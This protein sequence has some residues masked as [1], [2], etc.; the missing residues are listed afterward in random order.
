MT[1][2][3]NLWA[4]SSSMS[5]LRD[6]ATMYVSQLHI[7]PNVKSWGTVISHIFWGIGTIWEYL[8]RLSHLYCFLYRWGWLRK[9]KPTW[10]Q[11]NGYLNI[12]TRHKRPLLVSPKMIHP[13]NGLN[14]GWWNLKIIKPD[15]GKVR[16]AIS[17]SWIQF[18]KSDCPYLTSVF[19]WQNAQ[20]GKWFTRRKCNYEHFSLW[21][22]KELHPPNYLHLIF[23][24]L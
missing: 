21:K 16:N 9:L 2:A 1:D 24:I 22:H 14:T 5:C 6:F 17:V 11:S 23:D 4:S 19:F 3:M 13:K 7:Q 12:K 20:S 15:T 8:S 10:F 18:M